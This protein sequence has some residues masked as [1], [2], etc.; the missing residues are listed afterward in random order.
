[1]MIMI[2]LLL[3]LSQSLQLVSLVIWLLLLNRRLSGGGGTPHPGTRIL[4]NHEPQ[5]LTLDFRPSLYSLVARKTRGSLVCSLSLSFYPS[6]PPLLRFPPPTQPSMY[7]FLYSFQFGIILSLSLLVSFLRL[8]LSQPP[9]LFFV[10]L[11]CSLCL[12]SLPLS[13]RSLPSVANRPANPYGPSIRLSSSLFSLPFLLFYSSLR[14][15]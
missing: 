6:L 1:M 8:P 14:R 3:L 15:G 7:I 13:R 11:P 10:A 2:L 9:H 12:Q 4:S 5:L